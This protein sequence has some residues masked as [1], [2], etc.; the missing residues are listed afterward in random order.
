MFFAFA[1]VTLNVNAQSISNHS[2]ENWHSSSNL[3]VPDSFRT[4]DQVMATVNPTVS[5]SNEAHSGSFAAAIQ[6]VFLSPGVGM[7][8]QLHYGSMSDQGGVLRFFGWPCSDRPVSMRFYYKFARNGS[9]TAQASVTLTKWVNGQR[10][11]VGRG[12]VNI[13]SPVS[14]YT[15]CE[16]PVTYFSPAQPDSV[17]ISFVSGANLVPT[18]GTILYV[19][20]VSFGDVTS[21]ISKFTSSGTS[22]FPNPVRDIVTV[23]FE[24]SGI[25]FCTLFDQNGRKIGEFTESGLSHMIDFYNLKSGFYYLNVENDG[26]KDQL[27]LVKE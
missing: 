11:T 1:F 16:L 21:S 14:S 23:R 17:V 9:D 10:E 15:L 22:V 3:L 4:Q 25:K 12:L 20:D 6:N 5:R 8:G 19:D 27:V 24:W 2:F 26:R 18:P 7:S 13:T